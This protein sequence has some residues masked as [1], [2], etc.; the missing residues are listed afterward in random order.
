MNKILVIL[1]SIFLTAVYAFEANT[2]IA[3]AANPNE[4]IIV[5]GHQ[6]GYIT[7][8]DKESLK[9]KGTKKIGHNIKKLSFT[10]NGKYLWVIGYVEERKEK[11]YCVEVSDWTVDFKLSADKVNWSNTTDRLCYTIGYGDTQVHLLDMNTKSKIGAVDAKF[12]DPEMKID[13]LMFSSDGKELLVSGHKGYGNDEPG[14]V[15]VYKS[16]GYSKIHKKTIKSKK[17]F[18]DSFGHGVLSKDSTYFIFSWFNGRLFKGAEELVYPDYLTCYSVFAEPDGSFALIGSGRH[19]IER[20]D[21]NSPNSSKLTF[22]KIG[23]SE[24][25]VVSFSSD[26]KNVY[27]ITDEHLIGVIN[28]E[29][30]V[31][32][33]ELL[34]YKVNLI[35]RDYY[36]AEQAKEI[37]NQL[38]SLGYK[39]VVPEEYDKNNRVVIKSELTVEKAYD[40]VIEIREKTTLGIQTIVELFVE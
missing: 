37:E 25:G 5:I 1:L 26:G 2:P 18:S 34:T 21:I 33:Q 9:V 19:A 15:L 27:F 3:I 20:F 7:I 35:L 6:N 13:A 22:E 10:S 29:G 40:A 30:F 17:A 23:K 14:E 36:K 11:V 39:V 38:K 24:G 4:K 32:K 31:T 12:S 8:L 16:E 28:K